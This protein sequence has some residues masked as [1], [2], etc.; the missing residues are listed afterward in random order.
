MPPEN[1]SISTI[2]ARL[3]NWIFARTDQFT[4]GRNWVLKVLLLCVFFSIFFSGGIDFGWGEHG[5]YPEGYFKKIDHPL[6]DVAKISGLNSNEANLNF[7]LTVPVLLHLAGIHSHESL[8]ILTILAIGSILLAT[9]MVAY[10]ITGDRVCACFI[11]LNVSATYV[12]SFGFIFCYDA[13]A[14]CQLAWACLPGMKWWGRCLLVFTASFT[15]ER[16]FMASGLLLV[17]Y[18][19]LPVC[20]GGIFA[21]LRQ[22]NFLAVATAMFLY[23]IGRL[24]LMK[25]VGLSSPTGGCGGGCFI[26]NVGH[27]LHPAI[28]FALKGGWLFYGLALIALAGNK[29]YRSVGVLLLATLGFLGFALMIGDV[30][31]STVYIFPLL[32]ICLTVVRQNETLTLCRT[33]CLLAFLISALGGDYNVYISKI[34]WFQPLVVHWLQMGLQA[35]YDWLYFV[36]PH[37]IPRPST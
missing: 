34:T 4:A 29:N 26:H 36:L 11:A 35:L 30:L 32:F 6:M 12:G 1:A 9:C 8:P 10:R 23:V 27:F 7:R 25:V 15:D 16:A 18:F 19:F 22:P 31:K 21:R 28:W 37:T 3:Q 13:I 24:I 17:G 20:R 14:I 33:Y 2:L 5:P